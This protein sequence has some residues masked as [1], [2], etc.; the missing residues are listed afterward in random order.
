MAVNPGLY[1]QLYAETQYTEASR[2]VRLQP[3]YGGYYSGVLYDLVNIIKLN[4][5][6]ETAAK[7]SRKWF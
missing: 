5:D 7:V 6:P 3:D 4:T 1:A 2:Y